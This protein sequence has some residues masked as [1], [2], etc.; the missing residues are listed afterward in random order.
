MKICETTKRNVFFSF[1]KQLE[2]LYFVI[3]ETI[4]FRQNSD[5]F[6]TVSYIAKLKKDTKLSTLVTMGMKI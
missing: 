6:R 2:T 1:A 5:L 3:R 4:K